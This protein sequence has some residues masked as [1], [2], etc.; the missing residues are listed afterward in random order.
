MLYRIDLDFEGRLGGSN[1]KSKVQSLCPMVLTV[2][3]QKSPTN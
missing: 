2:P 1:P 3:R